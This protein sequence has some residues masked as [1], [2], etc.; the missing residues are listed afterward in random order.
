MSSRGGVSAKTG[1]LWEINTAL[2]VEP[3]LGVVAEVSFRKGEERP[4]AGKPVKLLA[5]VGVYRDDDSLSWVK[6]L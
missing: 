5:E 6:Y 4:E 2:I 3:A 1:E